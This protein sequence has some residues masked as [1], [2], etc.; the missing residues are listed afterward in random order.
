MFLTEEQNKANDKLLYD[1]VEKYW[2]LNEESLKLFK[3]KIKSKK[4][5]KEYKRF[6]LD[7]EGR[8]FYP[9]E[10]EELSEIDEGWNYFKSKFFTFKGIAEE[11]KYENFRK[12][13]VDVGKGQ[14][15]KLVNYLKE[16]IY[17]EYES[18]EKN[19][20]IE[21]T[22]YLNITFLKR[23]KIKDIIDNFVNEIF[24]LRINRMRLPKN[25]FFFVVSCNPVDF[26]LCS[27][28]QSWTSC[29][30]LIR[31]GYWDGLPSAIMD[32]N[33]AIVYITTGEQK[34][35]LGLTTYKI[36]TRSWIILLKDLNNKEENI[37]YHFVGRYPRNNINLDALSEKKL[38]IEL[39][40]LDDDGS[41]GFQSVYPIDMLPLKIGKRVLYTTIYL[42][43]LCVFRKKR[44]KEFYYS[45]DYSETDIQEGKV[46][47]IFKERKNNSLIRDDKSG[48]ILRADTPLPVVIQ[49][50]I[51]VYNRNE[52]EEEL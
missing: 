28:G 52:I 31:D 8:A 12:N 16:K 9:I 33:R 2:G 41:N 51:K 27:T 32:K 17:K 3:D 23:P 11:I 45:N 10:V 21:I 35:F 24:E 26:F 22:Q 19:K 6:N 50:K 47:F 48:I 49:E 20:K 4:Y 44:R 37:F 34:K 29:L 14:K 42:D 1:I 18:S 38:E 36:I 13:I 5:P 15:V 40:Y 39:N 25:D 7:K 43:T 30:N 46:T